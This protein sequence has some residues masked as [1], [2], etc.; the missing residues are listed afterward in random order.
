M[1][2]RPYQQDAFDAAR[3]WLTKTIDSCVIQAPTGAGKSHII[4]AIADWIHHT[5]GK[6]HVLC[7]APS[8]ELVVQNHAKYLA[9]GNPASIFSASAGSVSLRHPVVFGTP[10]TVKN[11]IRRFGD[12]FCAVIL[13]EAHRITPTVKHIIEQLQQQNPYLRVIGLSATPYRLGS[14]YIYEYDEQERF[15]EQARNP[16]FTRLIYQIYERD[17]IAQGYLTEPLV[18]EINSDNYHTL[19]MQVNSRGQFD[20]A[21]VDRAYHG[22]GRKTS[23]IV[24]DIVAQAKDRKGVILFAATVRHAEEVLASLPTALSAIVTGETKRQER[25]KILE[26]FKAQQIKYL[27][28]VAVLTTGFDAPHVD[29]IALLRATESVSLLQQMIGRGMRIAPG[30]QDCL[31]LDY[32]ENIERHCPD[33]DLFAPEIKVGASSGGEAI[34][35]KCPICKTVNQ[36]TAR[37]ND[38]GYELS[39]DGYF[40]DL[41]G[42]QVETEHGPMPSHYGRRCTGML[43]G[44]NYMHQ[45]CGHRWTVKTCP[46]CDEENDIAARYCTNCKAELV[47]PNEKLKLDFR[48]KKKDPTRIQCDRVINWTCRPTISRAGNE[49]LRIDYTTEYRT[50]SVWMMPTAKHVKAISEYAYFK[51]HTND[52]KQMPATIKYKKDASTGF[53]R[54]ID[55][56]K[57]PDMEPA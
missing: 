49:T 44:P 8:A 11:K 14:G 17:L 24:A 18:G 13:D 3:E 1:S 6:K 42:E 41:A 47:D 25:E 40:L 26:A 28:N 12:Q 23:G 54:V 15:V 50:F 37:K 29:L 53:Y 34:S 20:K 21:D 9:T 22:H 10:Q 48:A 30:K 57:P 19:D 5:S 35:V 4:A 31:V 51:Y 2:L 45:R 56:N 46:H 38:E 36:F 16:Y 43:L 32:A 55:Y 39:E 27:V 33:G 7:I 52:G